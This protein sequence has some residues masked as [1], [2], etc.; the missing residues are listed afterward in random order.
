[1]GAPW[2]PAICTLHYYLE[3]T[4]ARLGPTRL[5]AGSHLSGRPP[6][7]MDSHDVG[8]GGVPAQS[9]IVAAGDAIAF[10]SDVW[11]SG[12]LN[13]SEQARHLV[14]LH[15]ASGRVSVRLP[16][17]RAP[18]TP[19]DVQAGLTPRQARLLRGFEGV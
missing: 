7:P 8:W 3:D 16:P 1:M 10:R 2:A 13:R 18:A 17:V 12:A 9:A 14:Q 19:A 4:S 15:Y 11:H 5:V 6:Q